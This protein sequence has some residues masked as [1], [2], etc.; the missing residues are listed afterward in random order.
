M[1]VRQHEARFNKFDL[2]SKSD[3]VPDVDSM[4]EEEL[5]ALVKRL[6]EHPALRGGGGVAMQ[7]AELGPARMSCA[8]AA[9]ASRA[10]ATTRAQNGSGSLF[11]EVVLPLPAP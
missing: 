8:R 6:L 7:V 10:R 1:Q 5:R 2:Y 3:T 9:P 4:H 11:E